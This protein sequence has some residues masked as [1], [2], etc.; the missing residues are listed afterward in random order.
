MSR[1][2]ILTESQY[3]GLLNRIDNESFIV[4]DYA[5][6][7]AK[8]MQ[9]GAK[10]SLINATKCPA[11]YRTLTQQEKDSY[12]GIVKPWTDT[13][14]V[15]RN[16]ITLSNGTV[17]N[18]IQTGGDEI[19]IHKVVENIRSAMGSVV[20]IAAQVLIDF[21]PVAGPVIN[22]GAWSLLLSYDVYMGIA[23]NKWDWFNIIVDIIG[24]LTTGPGAGVAKKMLARFAKYGKGSLKS[25]L[26]VIKKADPK[27]FNYLYGMLKKATSAIGTVTSQM[28]KIVNVI[29]TKAKNTSFYKYLIQIKNVMA[30]IHKIIHEVE[31]N[32]LLVGAKTVAKFG[33]KYGE[34]YAEHQVVHAGV[35]KIT[36]H[37]HGEGHGGGQHKAVTQTVQKGLTQ[38]TGKLNPKTTI[39]RYITV[40]GIKKPNPKFKQTYGY[41]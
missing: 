7:V 39:P 26:M 1:T 35:G 21:I 5:A 40:N 14:N 10:Q 27:S 17:C 25:F 38:A 11:N 15:Y 4:E 13:R 18:K 3:N 22:S 19:D 37:G 29:A 31:G 9:A 16:W 36:G 33:E 2:L 34:K 23:N 32:I 20:G 12:K 8:R 28:N 41:A 6:D 30:R 24:I